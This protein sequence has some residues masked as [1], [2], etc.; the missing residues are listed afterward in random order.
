MNA[1]IYTGRKADLLTYATDAH[2]LELYAAYLTDEYAHTADAGLLRHIRRMQGFLGTLNSH[3]LEAACHINQLGIDALLTDICAVATWSH[4]KH[5]LQKVA[6]DTV[7]LDIEQR[8]LLGSDDSVDGAMLFIIDAEHIAIVRHQDAATTANM[9]PH[10]DA[11][12]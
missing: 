12:K 9:Q 7:P 11:K 10:W 2:T 6:H 5:P 1:D 3:G 4:W 8:G